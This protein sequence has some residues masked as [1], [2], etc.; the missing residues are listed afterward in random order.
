M[1]TA[2]DAAPL[3]AAMPGDDAGPAPE[4]SPAFAIFC[5]EVADALARPA[6]RKRALVRMAE[7][8][9]ALGDAS[10]ALY[11]T[12]HDG[13]LQCEVGSGD[14]AQLEGD[15]V[16]VE[17]T[18]EGEA[19]QTG[20]P[21]ATPNLRADPRAYLP[22]QRALP[23]APA[24]AVPLLQPTDRAGV[25]LLAKH[26]RDAEFGAPAVATLQLAATLAAGVLRSLDQ[27]ERARASRA[28]IEAW[29]SA[30]AR[31]AVAA[32]GI[33]RAVRHELNT[34][35]AVILGN[36]QLCASAD[37]AEW[38]L[39]VPEFWQA[40]R[41]GA[42]RLEELSRLLRTLDEAEAPVALDAQGRFIL[43]EAGGGA[44]G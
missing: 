22:I 18:L 14:L 16:P 29:R 36:L 21:C 37:P 4:E 43:P 39:P 24:L 40:I 28:V 30:Q 8:L 33:L 41:G 34:P 23:N 19:F 5:G 35:V 38:K 25:V 13:L 2:W 44:K 20:Q 1:S 12:G 6:E 11:T 15:L 3:A 32:Q 10:V 17:A 42:A 9:A 31:D 26:R 27:H 7:A